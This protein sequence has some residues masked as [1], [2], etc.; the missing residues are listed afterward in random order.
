MKMNVK[1]KVHEAKRRVSGMWGGRG[2]ENIGE[3]SLGKIRMKL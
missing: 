1:R 2:T 3:K